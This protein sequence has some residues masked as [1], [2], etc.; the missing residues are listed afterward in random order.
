MNLAQFLSKYKSGV[1]LFVA[2]N[3]SLLSLLVKNNFLSRGLDK[4][5]NLL[6]STKQTFVS[7]GDGFSEMI[8]KYSSY[9]RLQEDYQA[10]KAENKIAVQWKFKFDQLAEQYKREFKKANLP[11]ITEFPVMYA[12][13]IAS[14]PDNW[15]ST[16]IIDKGRNDGI[17]EYMPVIGFQVRKDLQ[18]ILKKKKKNQ[19]DTGL[20]TLD[21]MI[22]EIN[23]KGLIHG[24]VGKVI[25]VSDSTARILTINDQRSNLGIRL[26]RTGEYA[27][28]SGHQPNPIA[29]RLD[30]F[31]EIGDLFITSGGTGVFPGGLLV[32]M[33]HKKIET[34]TGIQI[35]V[36]PMLDLHR[37]DSV[38][39]ILR[40]PKFYKKE[41]SIMKEGALELTPEERRSIINNQSVDVS[42]KKDDQ[43][44]EENKKKENNNLIVKAKPK[45]KRKKGKTKQAKARNNK[46]LASAARKAEEQRLLRKL[47]K[48]RGSLKNKGAFAK[49]EKESLFEDDSIDPL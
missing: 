18:A 35:A 3:F 7:F 1:T 14:D 9:E 19:F 32:G 40:K 15:H 27:L 36:K 39:V 31:P 5:G 47:Q 34:P 22:P 29:R 45:K 13:V 30:V 42:V 20:P 41:F 37:L 10:L 25:Q 33:A 16:I 28:L 24:V 8:D 26:K 17:T 21:S 48:E 46:G 23:S 49:K 6:N 12:D 11:K 44:R 43:D 4:T 2:F 38:M